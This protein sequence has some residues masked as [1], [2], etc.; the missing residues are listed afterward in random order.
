[1]S[2]KMI[3]PNNLEVLKSQLSDLIKDGVVIPSEIEEKDSKMYHVVLIKSKPNPAKMKYDHNVQVQMY[4][5]RSFNKVKGQ[6]GRLGLG[7]LHILHDPKK[8]EAKGEDQGGSDGPTYSEKK[9]LA[10]ALELG[11]GNAPKGD[12]LDEALANYNAKLETA[13]EKGIQPKEDESPYTLAEVE[14]YLSGEE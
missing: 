13:I 1:M 7:T 14:A 9:K 2:K 10:K 4:N 5:D 12:V 6:A 3:T 11:L 8:A